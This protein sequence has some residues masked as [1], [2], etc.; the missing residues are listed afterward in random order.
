M[1]TVSVIIPTYGHRDFILE[2]LESVFAQSFTDFEIVVVN[3]GSLD[4]TAELLA[5]LI[6]SGRIR[7][8]AQPN[9]GQSVARNAGLAIAL[10]EYIAFLD[11]D[12]TW[13]PDKLAQQVAFL[14]ERPAAVGVAGQVV[15]DRERLRDT[16]PAPFVRI[17]SQ[18]FFSGNPIV[19]PGQ[20]LIRADVLHRLGGFDRAIRGAEDY[21]L[22]IRLEQ[23][24]ALYAGGPVALYYRR[25]P[26]GASNN[27]VQMF[28]ATS[29]VLEKHLRGRPIRER[30][31]LR[32]VGYR[33]LH[34]YKGRELHAHLYQLM[35]ERR[36]REWYQLV[37][38][39]R[40]YWMSY[41]NDPKLFYRSFVS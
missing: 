11:D 13:P 27:V 30:L 37:R 16:T 1:P 9:Q 26:Q 41:L 21:D 35:R 29:A 33:F 10:G 2:T 39:T 34:N 4:D 7:Y 12:D 20:T 31:T 3:D 22:W 23:E 24:G 15:S 17:D 40:A 6:A 28:I 8:L 18:R 25:H 14:R 36:Y 38:Q 32:R 19:S 5:P